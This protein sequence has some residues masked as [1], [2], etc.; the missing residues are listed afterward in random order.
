ML[1]YPPCSDMADLRK[2]KNEALEAAGKGNWR[3]AAWCYANLEKD[4]AAEPGWALKLGESLRKMGNDSEA[5]Q[6]LGRAVNGYAKNGLVLK[7]VAVCKIILGLDPNHAHAQELLDSFYA[8][9]RRP[10]DPGVQLPRRVPSPSSSAPTPIASVPGAAA[11]PAVLAPA[12]PDSFAVSSTMKVPR[13]AVPATVAPRASAAAQAS[14]APGDHAPPP[15]RHLRLA[16]LIPGSRLSQQVPSVGGSAAM[17]IP[18][19]EDFAPAAAPTNPHKGAGRNTLAH[20]VLPRTPFFSVLSRELFR[21][22]VERV[23][24]I[25][26]AAGETLFSQGDPGDELY[27]VA[28]GEIAVLAPR[29]IARLVEGEFFGEIAML[30]DRPRN[31]TVRA[32]VDSQVLAIDRALLGDLV[33]GSPELLKVLLRFLRDRLVATLAETSPLFAPFTP[34]ERLGLAARF[35]CLEID[36]G[37]RILEKGG[38]SPGLFVLLAGEANAV[39]GGRIVARLESGDAFGEI[40][41]I[42]NQPATASIETLC[43]SFVLYLPRADFSEIIMTHPQVLEYISSLAEERMREIGRIDLL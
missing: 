43:K 28:W 36:E 32:T 17:E 7:A 13:A 3:K 26:L 11:P 15:M 27:V 5:V 30:A 2:L 23:R 16:A 41:L 39:T 19:D 1:K 38:K 34:L 10:T 20:F 14:A 31:A 33:K 24:L 25:Q 6:A 21:E 37:L 4:E 22:A 40:S 9:Q 12:P 29:E 35:H 8:A 42:T 18:I